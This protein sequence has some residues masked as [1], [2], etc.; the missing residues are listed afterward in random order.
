VKI[1]W[2]FSKDQISLAITNKTEHSININWDEAAYVDLLSLSHRVIHSGVNYLNRNSPQTKSVI[3]KQE[4]LIDFITPSDYIYF[5]MGKWRKLPILPNYYQD[6]Q[7]DE[8]LLENV[9]KK[10]SVLLPIEIEGVV[11]EYI[12]KFNIDSV[13]VKELLKQ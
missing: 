11:N 4:I 8:F 1:L 6:M 9:G 12:F 7:L 13:S 3:V 10:I 5:L 2:S